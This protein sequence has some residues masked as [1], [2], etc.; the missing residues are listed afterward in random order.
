MDRL[1]FTEKLLT[2]NGYFENN[3]AMLR[4]K[5]SGYL[6]KIMATTHAEDLSKRLTKQDIIDIVY[7]STVRDIIAGN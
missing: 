6:A 4:D 2:D 5:A 1:A 3:E 7:H